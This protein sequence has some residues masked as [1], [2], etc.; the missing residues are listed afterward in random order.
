MDKLCGKDV[1]FL[2]MNRWINSVRVSPAA[3]DWSD[4]THQHSAQ[5]LFVHVLFR[6]FPQLLSTLNFTHLPLVEHN[7]YPVSTAPTINTTIT[8][9]KERL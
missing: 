9:F 3:M 2:R 6:L 1:Q 4:T 8:K 5:P 7:F